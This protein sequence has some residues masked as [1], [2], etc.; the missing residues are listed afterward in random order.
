MKSLIKIRNCLFTRAYMTQ[1]TA[2]L[3]LVILWLR[4]LAHSIKLNALKSLLW[5]LVLAKVLC[6]MV[7]HGL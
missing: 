6:C 3:S 1:D 5:P 7:V 4:L 2:F